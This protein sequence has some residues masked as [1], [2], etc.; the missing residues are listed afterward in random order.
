MQALQQ[1]ENDNQAAIKSMRPVATTAPFEYHSYHQDQRNDHSN[2]VAEQEGM[3]HKS[4]QQHGISLQLR[5][6][7]L[8]Q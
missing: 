2:E 4:D 1:N 3:L 5:D 8:S 6:Q 7:L